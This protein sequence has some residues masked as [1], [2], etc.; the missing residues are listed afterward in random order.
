MKSQ[1]HGRQSEL[2]QALHERMRRQLSLGRCFVMT[3]DEIKVV[4]EAG[5]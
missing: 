3:P 5:K 4:E 2:K 1:R